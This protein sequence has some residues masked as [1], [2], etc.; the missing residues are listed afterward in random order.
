MDFKHWLYKLT[1]CQILWE[2]DRSC[3]RYRS[4]KHSQYSIQILKNVIFGLSEFQNEF[5][6]LSP[7]WVCYMRPRAMTHNFL[8]TVSKGR[9][10]LKLNRG[11]ALFS[12]LGRPYLPEFRSSYLLNII[13]IWGLNWNQLCYIQTWHEEHRAFVVN[14]RSS[15]DQT[16]P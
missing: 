11:S 5:Q 10:C 14:L 16:N 15:T 7:A 1:R 2:L 4:I 6:M 12:M 3:N 8:Q 13:I 9:A